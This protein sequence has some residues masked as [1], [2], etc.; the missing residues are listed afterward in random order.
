MNIDYDL[1][2]LLFQAYGAEH[3]EYSAI[4]GDV[5]DYEVPIIDLFYVCTRED[6]FGCN[7]S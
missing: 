5:N 2:C 6:G 7:Q 3:D 1:C 4:F